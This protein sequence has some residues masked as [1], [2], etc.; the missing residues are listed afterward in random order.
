[1]VRKVAGK[2]LLM[3]P[4]RLP[5]DEPSLSQNIRPER[6]DV[7]LKSQEQIDEEKRLSKLVGILGSRS[8]WL[9]S[10]RI[11]TEERQRKEQAAHDGLKTKPSL[12]RVVEPLDKELLEV[13]AIDRRDEFYANLEKERV[14]RT[15]LRFIEEE[16]IVESVPVQDAVDVGDEEPIDDDEKTPR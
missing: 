2:P 5:S 16:L 1:M 7:T 12:Y 6:V 15:A 11:A 4:S 10:A 13:P 9:H 3:E 8:Y 14:K